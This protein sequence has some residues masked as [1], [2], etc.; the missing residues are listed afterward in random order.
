MC[1]NMHLRYTAIHA[2]QMQVRMH[3]DDGMI[4][5][6]TRQSGRTRQGQLTLGA[7][8]RDAP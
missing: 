3:G 7:A 4:T 8:E 1:L 5:A 2:V 6:V